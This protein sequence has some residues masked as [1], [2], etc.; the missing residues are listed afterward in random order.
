MQNNIMSTKPIPT[1]MLKMGIPFIISLIVQGLYNVIDSAFVSNMAT[2][3]EEGVNALALAFPIQ[4]LFIACSIGVGIGG[5]AML[6]KFLGMGKPSL[7]SKVAG[8]LIVLGIPILIIFILF[9]IFGSAPYIMSQTT[10]PVIIDMGT[11]YLTI[12]CVISI[13]FVYFGLFEKMLQ[14]TGHP[15]C[16]MIA[17]LIGAVTNII[18]DPIMIYGL[19][20][21]PEMGVRGAA[22]ASVFGQLVSAIIVCIFYFKYTKEI[23][24]SAKNYI[25]DSSI[26]KGILKIGGPAI[27]MQAM[28]SFMTY[29]LNLIFVSVS[30]NI[31]TAFGIFFKIQQMIMFGVYGLRDA[32]TPIVAFNFGA[33][34]KDRI[35]TGVKFGVIYSAIIGLMG[36]AVCEIFAMPIT[37][38]FGLSGVTAGYCV[39]A[40]RLV[41]ISFVFAAMSLALQGVFQALNGGIQSLIVTLLRQ[42]ILIL[43]VAYLFAQAAIKD[44][45]LIWTLWLTF[46]I[47]EIATC[48][49]AFIM[50]LKLRKKTI[51]GI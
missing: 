11:E 5:N 21:F 43:P 38:L 14:A 48:A 15:L 50:Y 7:A 45:S 18:L 2:Y 31:V 33:A 34:D 42:L 22:L 36:T 10:N 6:S 27:A 24:K 29:G 37:E 35:L 32:I 51:D 28:A 39:Q 23:D 44:S 47:A 1:L 41:S 8:N 20:G 40:L 19:L 4:T 49:V 9:G 46:I 30:E 17:Q 16:T 26:I 25:P 12:C 13:G 3:G